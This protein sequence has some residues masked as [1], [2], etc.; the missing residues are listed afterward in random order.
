MNV[1]WQKIHDAF[2]VNQHLVWLNNCGVAPPGRQVVEKMSRFLE[3]YAQRGVCA[4]EASPGKIRS[5]IKEILSGLLGCDPSELALIHNTAEGMNAVSRGLS[6]RSGDEILLLE[7][8]YPSNV[9][10]WLHWK[11]K[12]VSVTT[13]PAVDTPEAFLEVFERSLG[14]R[15]RVAALSA[16]H[17]C[18]GLPL[19]LKSIGRLCRERG[20][21]L[22]VDG[23]QG[24]GMQPID[25]RE[26]QVTCMAFSAWKW[27]IGPLGLGV[28]F[29]S[30]DRLESLTPV[31]VGTESVVRDEEYLPYKSELKPTADR[32]TFSTSSLTDWIYFEA[33]LEFLSQVGFSTVMERIYTLTGILN[34]G[35]AALGFEVFSERFPDHP[36]GITA[37]R[38]PGLNSSDVV[39][40]LKRNGVVAA[41]RLGRI[42]FSPHIYLLPPQLERVSDLLSAL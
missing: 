36:T 23:A 2:P 31:F 1:H 4:P 35:L 5:R 14:P 15:T 29:I 24:V 41:E 32:F 27:L 21:D 28:L 12:G 19:P 10:P 38:K 20:I 6:L 37:C 13:L 39:A 40:Y 18:T 33:A 34:Q 26:A 22:V 16:V 8:E 9:Y 7:H 25:L 17:W 11:E 42:R 3:S 30:R